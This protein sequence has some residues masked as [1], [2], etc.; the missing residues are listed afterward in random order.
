MA[1]FLAK[2]WLLGKN[3]KN[4]STGWLD[5]PTRSEG[6]RVRRDDMWEGWLSLSGN[7]PD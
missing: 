7:E 1:E 3:S 6:C 5:Q 2:F 4:Y